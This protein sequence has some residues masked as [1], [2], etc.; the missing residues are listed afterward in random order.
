M[1]AKLL[2]STLF[3]LICVM[4]FAIVGAAAEYTVHSNSEFDS[5]FASAS[6]GDTIIIKGNISSK[7]D[8]G[9]SITYILDGDGIVWSAGVNCTATGKTVSVLSKNGDNSFRPNAGM[10]SNSYGLTVDNLSSSKWILGSAD[11]VGTLKLDL[12]VVDG[13]L[14]YGTFLNEIT[15]LSGTVVTNLYSTN[16]SGDTNYIKCTTLNICDGVKIYGNSSN[17]PLIDVTTLNMYGGEI[18]GNVCTGMWSGINA[19]Q[20]NMYGGSIHDNYQPSPHSVNT[21]ANDPQTVAFISTYNASIYDGRIYNNFVGFGHPSEIRGTAA[22]IGTRSNGYTL[23]AKENAIDKNILVTLNTFGAFTLDENGYYTCEIDPKNYENIIDNGDGTYTYS[24]QYLRATLSPFSH[25]VIFKSPNGFVIEAFMIKNDQSVLK[26]VS[27][28]T[29][30]A[31]PSVYDAWVNDKNGSCVN[32]VIPAFEAQTTYFGTNHN[33]DAGKL[34]VSYPDGFVK[35]G[36]QGNPCTICTYIDKNDVILN[37]IF[38]ASGYACSSDGIAGG[39]TIDTKALAFYNA[40]NSSGADGKALALNFG[41]IMLNPVYLGETIF[42]NDMTLNASGGFLQVEADSNE[43]SN[44]GFFIRGFSSDALQNLDLVIAMYVI[45]G[46]NVEFIQKDY[47]NASSSPIT[48]TV[49]QS[50]NKLYTVNLLSVTAYHASLEAQAVAIV[51]DDEE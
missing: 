19:T 27:G 36:I 5:A 41:I 14:F 33:I 46:E 10:W 42:K 15:L 28:A 40:N 4:A 51:K 47:S 1:R 32:A 12:D 6:D 30:T 8:F 31:I 21:N 39:F 13:R 26:S 9:R 38:N 24:R 35:N 18:L 50:Q 29:A 2:L 23:Y 25:S 17:K 16:A 3:A 11:D 44:L 43:Y 48:S 7:L 49:A 45:D 22:G 20:F 37:P 34:V